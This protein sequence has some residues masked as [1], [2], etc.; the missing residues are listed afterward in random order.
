MCLGV[1]AACPA[2]LTEDS[3]GSPGTGVKDHCE[4]SHG[5]WEWNWGPLEEWA[6]PLTDEPSLYPI[7]KEALKRETQ[8]FIVGHA[9]N[10]S[11]WGAEAGGLL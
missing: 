5:S 6:V 11:T 10:F 7:G 2:V 1:W 9:C 4:P 8:S 3:V